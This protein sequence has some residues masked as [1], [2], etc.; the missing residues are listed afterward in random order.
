MSEWAGLSWRPSVERGCSGDFEFSNF[1]VSMGTGEIREGVIHGFEGWNGMETD[2]KECR[3][4]KLNKN[5]ND[6]TY[7][8]QIDMIITKIDCSRNHSGGKYTEKI[9]IPKRA[10]QLPNTQI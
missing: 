7:D 6:D 5:V 1:Q 3:Q 8:K 4:I 9:G 10:S 2:K